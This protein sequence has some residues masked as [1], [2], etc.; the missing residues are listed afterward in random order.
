MESA[1]SSEDE[2]NIKDHRKSEHL[3]FVSEMFV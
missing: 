3:M 1:G 2:I